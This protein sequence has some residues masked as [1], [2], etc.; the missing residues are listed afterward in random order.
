MLASLVPYVQVV[1]GKSILDGSLEVVAL[2]H[3]LGHS[4]DQNAL[5][6]GPSYHSHNHIKAVACFPYAK[7]GTGCLWVV[8]IHDYHI[9]LWGLDRTF[10]S[11]FII[12]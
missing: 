7:E 2:Y 1:Q 9:G 10:L 11:K 6:V 3:T 4:K 5:E 8:D 12:I